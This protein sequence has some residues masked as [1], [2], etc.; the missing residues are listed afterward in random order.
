MK[1]TYST[2]PESVQNAYNRYER[3]VSR[4]KV[5]VDLIGALVDIETQLGTLS[6]EQKEGL[7]TRVTER[8]LM[9]IKELRKLPLSERTIPGWTTTDEAVAMSAATFLM[10]VGYAMPTDA[11]QARIVY[12]PLLA[13]HEATPRNQVV[14]NMLKEFSYLGQRKE[15][16]CS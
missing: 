12:G 16:V 9:K 8:A 10:R 3:A 13:V 6:S 5:D 2:L 1:Q 15:S 11:D 4:P 7:A 14:A